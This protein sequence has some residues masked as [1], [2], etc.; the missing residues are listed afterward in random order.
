M[1]NAVV[2]VTHHDPETNQY[3]VLPCPSDGSRNRHP[4]REGGV[5]RVFCPDCGREDDAVLPSGE[6]FPP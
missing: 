1:A 4:V 5:V 3:G 6:P 2:D